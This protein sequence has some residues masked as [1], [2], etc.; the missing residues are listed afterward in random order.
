MSMPQGVV[1][2]RRHSPGPE[3]LFADLDLLDLDD[4]NALAENLH[5]LQ[6]CHPLPLADLPL[7][8]INVADDCCPSR[9]KSLLVGTGNL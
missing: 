8:I 1:Q 3:L 7:A 9:C 6:Q 4:V 5:R 2:E